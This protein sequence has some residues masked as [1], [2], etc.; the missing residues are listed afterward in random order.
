MTAKYTE[1]QITKLR[2]YAEF[3]DLSSI[4][5]AINYCTKCHFCG[6]KCN[7][8]IHIHSHNYCKKRCADLSED[9]NYCCFRGESCKICSNYSICK[10]KLI[11][12]GYTIDQCNK[13]LS[14]E[15]EFTYKLK[16]NNSGVTFETKILSKTISTGKPATI[17][18]IVKYKSSTFIAQLNYYDKENIVEDDYINSNVYNISIKDLGEVLMSYTEIH[19]KDLYSKEEIEEI[20]YSI[21][22]TNDWKQELD[23][24][25]EIFDGCSLEPVRKYSEVVKSSS[26]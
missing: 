20:E 2:Q 12:A 15:K 10:G 1:S 7:M 19:N 26:C 18:H 17:S 3:Y 22:E 23:T 21:L 25:Y 16:S 5:K 11:S 24:Y 6:K 13:R 4:N 14:S 9:F 8:S